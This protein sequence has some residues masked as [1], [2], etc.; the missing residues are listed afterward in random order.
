[1][2]DERP[3]SAAA[4]RSNAADSSLPKYPASSHATRM[5]FARSVPVFEREARVKFSYSSGGDIESD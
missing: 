1:M 5:S 4:I 2:I 3:I